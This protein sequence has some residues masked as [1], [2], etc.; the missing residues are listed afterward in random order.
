MPSKMI[1]FH[2]ELNAETV[3]ELIAMI[4]GSN[5]KSVWIYFTSE[6]G[7]TGCADIL[8]DFLV[9]TDKRIKLIGTGFIESC[10]FRV[11]LTAPCEKT[12]LPSANAMLHNVYI[13]YGDK[14]IKKTK[15]MTKTEES[16]LAC[17]YE[18]NMN[19]YQIYRDH[20]VTEDIIDI[21]KTGI[22]YYLTYEQFKAI[23][24]KQIYDKKNKKL[25]IKEGSKEYA[26]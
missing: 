26:V 3:T 1:I 23:I 21:M 17:S 6:G 9:N 2:N 8:L 19:V 10:A 16:L 7:R 4:Q 25:I 15:R 22:D 24:D 5:Y 14:P 20:G 12:L 11:F 18:E 13:D